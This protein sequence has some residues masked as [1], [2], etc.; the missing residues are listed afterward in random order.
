MAKQITPEEMAKRLQHGEE[1]IVID[2]RENSE[3]AT[4]KIPGA[5]HIPLGQL[6]LRKNELNKDKSYIITCQSGNRSKAACGI[7]EALGYQVEDMK[8]GMNNWNGD[9]E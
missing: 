3:V 5:K 1:V 4:G 7:L 2:V 6:A 9:T 8:G